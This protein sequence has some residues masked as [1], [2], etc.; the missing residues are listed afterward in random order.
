MTT[1]EKIF[2]ES[3]YLFARFGYGNVSLRDIAKKVGITA[4]SIYGHYENKL[5]ILDDILFNYKERIDAYYP[6]PEEFEALADTLSVKEIL[7]KLFFQFKPSD[8]D[9]MMNATAIII[10]ERFNNSHADNCYSVYFLDR[11]IKRICDVLEM[12]IRKN[13]LLPF[14]CG[15]QARLWVYAINSVAME[16]TR[17]VSSISDKHIPSPE[18][19]SE[20]VRVDIL[21]DFAYK[22]LAN[23]LI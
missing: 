4:G 20:G 9:F 5:E 22:L 10:R 18:N 7:G 13:K 16:A 19:L 8:Y 17:A 1:K 15:I 14:D 3:A 12:L 21:N 6:T 23:Y 2:D 11:A